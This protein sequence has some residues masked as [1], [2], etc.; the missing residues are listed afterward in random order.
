V[1]LR[2]GIATVADFATRETRHWRRSH[3]WLRDKA[4]GYRVVW[5]REPLPI[6]L[7]RKASRALARTVEA[8]TDTVRGGWWHFADG[9]RLLVALPSKHAQAFAA[10]I[11]AVPAPE[12]STGA[13]KNCGAASVEGA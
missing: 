9:R 3:A 10:F 11:G 8:P 6:N 7:A 4:T 13:E 5:L 2:A 1:T 12:K